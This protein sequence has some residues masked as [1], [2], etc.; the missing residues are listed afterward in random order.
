MQIG[1]KQGMYTSCEIYVDNLASSAGN[2]VAHLQL[3]I[4][5]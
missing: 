4:G 3:P 2:K 1:R 5:F